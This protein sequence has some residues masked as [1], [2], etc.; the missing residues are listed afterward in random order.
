V[1]AY[2]ESRARDAGVKTIHLDVNRD[3]TPAISFYRKHGFV[4]GEDITF[5]RVVMMKSLTD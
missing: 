1:L 5:R 2:V 4:K 3:N